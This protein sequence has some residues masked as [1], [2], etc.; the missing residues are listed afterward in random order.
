MGYLG[1]R[2]SPRG[3]RWRPSK[4][5]QRVILSR[6]HDHVFSGRP[7]AVQ[8]LKSSENPR[9]GPGRRRSIDTMLL[10]C[11]TARQLLEA[12]ASCSRRSTHHKVWAG[13]TGHAAAD[14]AATVAVAFFDVFAVD[15]GS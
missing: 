6:Q 8:R 7:Q 1:D 3:D 12:C 2:P 15:T 10:H 9:R 5:R 13:R 4:V 11:G 14:V